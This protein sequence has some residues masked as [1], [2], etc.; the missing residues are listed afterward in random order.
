MEKR[1]PNIRQYTEVIR[2][3]GQSCKINILLEGQGTE[4]LVFVHGLTS[5]S[6]VWD[7]IIPHFS[8]RYQC[9]RFDLP[10]HGESG[11]CFEYSI[12]LFVAC[13]Q[14]I[15]QRFVTGPFSLIGH[16]LG[17]LVSIVFSARFHNLVNKLVLLAPAGL[18]QFSPAERQILIQ[19]VSSNAFQSGLYTKM[20]MEMKNR[21]TN[22]N[23]SDHAVWDGLW[24]KYQQK[25]RPSD[26]KLLKEC[27]GAMLAYPTHDYLHK[28]QQPTLLVFGEADVLIPNRLFHGR[29]T[30]KIAE[31]G[32]AAIPNCEMV[33]FENCGHYLQRE[34]PERFNL[35]LYKFLTEAI[36]RKN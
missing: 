19:M 35:A 29:N 8:S 23:S 15:A 20:L 30:R 5:S 17:G 1:H 3:D 36:T 21:F 34:Q 16:S 12:E 7:Q 14:Q 18:E 26:P 4:T 31:D 22:G 24:D 11:T 6:E 32:A 10:G 25:I 9:L 33:I 13:L 28:V 2:T 27:I